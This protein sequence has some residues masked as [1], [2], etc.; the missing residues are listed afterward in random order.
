LSEF[1]LPDS[2]ICTQLQEMSYRLEHEERLTSAAVEP[3]KK[4]L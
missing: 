3:G 1:L 2:H 4:E